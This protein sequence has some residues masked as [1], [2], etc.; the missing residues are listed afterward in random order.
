MQ[1]LVAHKVKDHFVFSSLSDPA[2][3][4]VVLLPDAISH[5]GTNFLQ[6]KSSDVICYSKILGVARCA[7]PAERAETQRED[8]PAV[9]GRRRVGSLTIHDRKKIL[10]LA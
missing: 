3:V 8:V 10:M 7:H 9:K 2:D 6:D 5:V 1:A 4:V